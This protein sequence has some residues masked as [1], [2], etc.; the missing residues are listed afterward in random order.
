MTA[1]HKDKIQSI[2][3]RKR[4]THLEPPEVPGDDGVPELHLVQ[5]GHGEGGGKQDAAHDP[6]DGSEHPEV[7][8]RDA[9]AAPRAVLLLPLLLPRRAAQPPDVGGADPDPHLPGP[10]SR[11]HRRRR[12]R[13]RRSR[14]RTSS[15]HSRRERARWSIK[16]A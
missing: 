16:A 2:G 14:R 9:D 8:R 11:L 1:P 5:R 10:A 3:N 13:R 15:L 6:D 7:P 12:R 4:G